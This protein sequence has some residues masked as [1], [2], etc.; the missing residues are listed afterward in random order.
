L[1]RIHWRLYKENWETQFSLWKSR[2]KC[3]LSLRRDEF[4]S[5][6]SNSFPNFQQLHEVAWNL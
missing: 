1:L 2:H 3:R 5:R 4:H 6:L